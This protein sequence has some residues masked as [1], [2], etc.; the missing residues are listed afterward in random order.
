MRSGAQRRAIEIGPGVATFAR[1]RGQLEGAALELA[2]GDRLRLAWSRG[3]LLALVSDHDGPAEPPRVPPPWTVFRRE[4]ELRRSIATLYPG[5][6]L[7][8]FEVVSRGPSGR[9]GKL[10]L[11]GQRGDT[12]LIEGLAVRWTLGTPET[13]FDA[14][15][16][17][18]DGQRGWALEGRGRG[19]GVGLCQLGAVAMSRRGHSYREILA[20]YYSGAKLG[21]LQT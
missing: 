14:R 1:R 9:V 2:A 21:R 5:F 8:D 17:V 11:L 7:R 3:R 10:R 19:H 16:E 13:W 6:V 18:R 12:V 20:H 4:D 15:R